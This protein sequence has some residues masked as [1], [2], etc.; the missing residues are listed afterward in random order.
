LI[1]ARCRS[2]G[3][4]DNLLIECEAELR[5][6]ESQYSPEVFRELQQIQQEI[7]QAW[8]EQP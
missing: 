4:T 8:N 5:Q 1:E 6:I 7:R 3:T 2:A